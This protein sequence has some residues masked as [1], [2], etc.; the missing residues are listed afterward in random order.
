MNTTMAPRSIGRLHAGTA[1][2]G[3]PPV[4][5]S[6]GGAASSPQKS[7]SSSSSVRL[8]SVSS[9]CA[10][11]AATSSVRLSSASSSCAGPAATSAV[12]AAVTVAP[13]P[14]RRLSAPTSDANVFPRTHRTCRYPS[15]SMWKPHPTAELC[16]NAVRGVLVPTRNCVRTWRHAQNVSTASMTSV[17]TWRSRPTPTVASSADS[18]PSPVIST[19][20][21]RECRAIA[22]RTFQ[23]VFFFFAA[24]NDV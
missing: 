1:P 5:T 18:F 3:R 7:S 17:A 16:V 11:P 8:S 19:L 9:S 20:R 14:R 2:A 21:R 15:S 22:V 6:V 13:P 10:G 4:V 12:V 23:N 24:T